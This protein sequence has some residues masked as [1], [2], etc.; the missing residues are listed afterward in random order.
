[1]VSMSKQK[2]T[3]KR[4]RKVVFVSL[5]D[6]TDAAL[7]QFRKAQRISPERSAVGYTAIIEFLRREGYLKSPPP[8]K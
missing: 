2:P 3:P 6:D 4:E 8:S 5:D 1:M 7:E